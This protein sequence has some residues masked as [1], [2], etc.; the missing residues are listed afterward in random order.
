MAQQGPTDLPSKQLYMIARKDAILRLP[1]PSVPDPYILRPYRPGDEIS[2]AETLVLGGFTSWDVARVL[3]FLEAAERREGSLVV[4]SG[5]RIV[6]GTFASRASNRPGGPPRISTDVTRLSKEGVLDYVVT[7]PD[8]QGRGLARATS[9]GV[10][11]FLI[12]R[13]CELVSLAT[14]DWRLPAIH[15]YL[16]MGYQPVMDRE[17]MSD[18]WT[19]VLQQ[20][21]EGGRN[22]A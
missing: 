17:D 3:L 10:S 9:T 5:G 12:D 11:R 1:K 14:D 4:E 18:R 19:T 22:Y 16:S 7:D 8:H 21:K 6:A 20:L 2:W 15:I 13:G